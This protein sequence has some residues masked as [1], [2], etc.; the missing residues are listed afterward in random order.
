MAVYGNSDSH[1]VFFY[2]CSY[3]NMNNK[4]NMIT[5]WQREVKVTIGLSHYSRSLLKQLEASTA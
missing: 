2:A 4:I 3:M 1:V 5:K